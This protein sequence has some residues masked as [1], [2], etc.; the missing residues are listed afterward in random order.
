MN[1]P[2][3][4]QKAFLL[5]LIAVSVAFI[6]ILLP[7]YG[8]V[9]WA[10]VLAIIFTP[11]H[12]KLQAALGQ[13]RNLAAFTTL[14]LILVIVILPVTLMTISLLQEGTIVYQKIRSG[15]LNFGMYFQQIASASPPWLVNL[16][17]RSGL[18]N[19]AELQD[20]LSSG[21]LRG[22]QFVA[23][24]A[25]S[26]GQ[27]AFEFLVSFGIMLYLLFFLLRDG[28][29]LA[30]KIKQ[31]MPLTMEHKRHLSSKFTTVIRATV[32]GN[33][34]VAAI[35][36]ALGGV[37]FYFLGIQGA[38]LWGFMMAFLSLIPAV[39]AGLIW[40]PV[41]I[42]FLFTGAVWQG[43][44]LIAF[45][46]FVIGLVDNL[47]R[48]VLVGRDTKMPDYVVLISTLG[49]LV[50]FGLNGFVIGPVIAALFMS[51]WDLFAAAMDTPRIERKD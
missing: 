14:L 41:A 38:L 47:L 31:A 45:G 21:V 1:S 15:E 26:L 50:L 6:W 33:V 11:F 46:V 9:F 29:N 28:D 37:V 48:P 5:M 25:L 43:T 18:T 12:R 42:Y 51:A 2:E 4:R 8:T 22:S 3:L 32:K 17:D 34:A 44:V 35:Q 30:A 10:A 16:L 20:M 13:H 24:H 23:T 49:G 39:G 19:M 7:F 40:I 27:N 36:G